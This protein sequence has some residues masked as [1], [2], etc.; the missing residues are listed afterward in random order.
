MEAYRI[1]RRSE[2]AQLWLVIRHAHNS[3]EDNPESVLPPI[4]PAQPDDEDDDELD[5]FDAIAMV[6]RARETKGR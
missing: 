2:L 1:R 6:R 5:D 3:E 4:A